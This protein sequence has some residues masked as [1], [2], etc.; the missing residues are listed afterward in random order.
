MLRGTAFLHAHPEGYFQR[1]LEL[2]LRPDGRAFQDIRSAAAY[3]GV[4]KHTV[5]SALLAAGR[6]RFV[7]GVTAELGPP[8]AAVPSTGRVLVNVEFSKT[9]GADADAV[10]AL[11]TQTAA[12]VS[13][14][15]SSPDVLDLRQ[16]CVKE[17]TCAWTLLVNVLCIEYDG[18]S[19]DWVVATAAAALRDTCLPS[20]EW[21]PKAQWWRVTTGTPVSPTAD[22][23]TWAG[24]GVTLRAWPV[25][26]SV[27]RILGQYWIADPTADEE[28]LGSILTVWRGGP[29]GPVHVL[30][31]HRRD[32][33]GEGSDE[34]AALVA[35]LVTG[36]LVTMQRIVDAALAS[37]KP[38]AAGD[39]LWVLSGDASDSG[40]EDEE[41]S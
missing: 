17:D 30:R 9:C 37:A 26:V 1:F 39:E 10:P 22:I 21:C 16:L 5:G 35:A 18:N 13:Q 3:Q 28:A 31:R 7:A 38:G 14:I 36:P 33:P 24:R 19:L 23:P 2:G 34:V 4:L 6:T 41:A 25:C 32:S 20:L 12:A 27:G 11:A 8:P 15:L 40:K 29:D